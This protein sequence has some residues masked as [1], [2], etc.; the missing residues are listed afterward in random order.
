MF[1]EQVLNGIIIGLPLMLTLG[2]ISI[3]LINQGMNAGSRSGIPAALGVASADLTM[4]MI[5]AAAGSA[6]VATLSPVSGVLRLVAAAVIV[7]LA[8]KVGLGARLQLVTIRRGEG[9]QPDAFTPRRSFGDLRGGRLA[10]TFYGMTIVNPISL[11]LLSAVVV[12]GGKGI[13]TPGWV[14]G[15][16]L[17]SLFAHTG[18]V[19]FGS[20]LRRTFNPVGLARVGMI[21]AVLMVATAAH[22]VTG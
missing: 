22:L 13:G 16:T 11:I 12:A 21:S 3:L 17:A 18:Y 2:P 1:T 7:G 10:G 5:A 6:L 8:V 20:F 19:M 4:S 14:V 9:G 15:M